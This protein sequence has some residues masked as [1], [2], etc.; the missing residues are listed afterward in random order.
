ML[1]DQ[2]VLGRYRVVDLFPEGGQAE[3]ATGGDE[4]TGAAVVIRR[5]KASPGDSNYAAERAR[6][7]RAARLRI[8]H[9]GVV[10][11]LD[12]GEADGA[13]YMI[14]PFVEGPTL[15]GYRIAQK[16]KLD[17]GRAAAIIRSIAEG[18]AA[19]HDRGVIH[20]DVNPRN[21]LIDRDEQ[22]RI[23]DF[24]ISSLA[25][26]PTITQGNGFQGT[27]GFAAPEQYFDPRVQDP[28]VDQYPLGAIGYLLLTGKKPAADGTPAQVMH[29]SCNITP[30]SPR[31]LDPAISGFMSDLCMRLLAKR[32][33]DR[34]TSMRELIHAIDSG[35]RNGDRLASCPFCGQRAAAP[36]SFCIQCGAEL[37][38][39][40]AGTVTTQ[41]LA[42]GAQSADA[43]A[44][45]AC[46]RA[47]SEADHR[48]EF[49][50][51]PLSGR[52]F[53]IPTGMYVIGRAALAPRD[54]HISRQHLRVA[55]M[56]GDLMIEDAGS[57]NG[58]LIDGRPL[59]QALTLNPNCQI[60][61]AGNTGVY[62]K[63]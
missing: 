47:F 36:S 53:R 39:P 57:S 56:N 6:F 2:L 38:V 58:T 31:E 32:A 5:L 27:L 49:S 43:S 41:C 50:G 25:G 54:S 44:C 22:P 19:C 42:C 14:L 12:A 10:D 23:I 59:D 61:I 30:P 48:I 13:C 55:C 63:N 24:G 8:G 11:P 35:T 46:R 20:R 34:F 18:L 1:L 45:P 9:P 17:C 4:V 33:G 28:R 62:R 37:S 29:D 15:E 40:A 52:I 3:L 51:G 26:E 21:I 16:G 60:V 7:W